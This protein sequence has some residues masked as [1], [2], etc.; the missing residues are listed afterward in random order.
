MNLD[1][2][3]SIDRLKSTDL[4]QAPQR[5]LGDARERAQAVRHDLHTRRESSRVALWTLSAEALEKA[6]DALEKAPAP[7]APVTGRLRKAVH[8][9]LN[10][11][12]KL[13]VEGYDDLNVKAVADLLPGLDRVNLERVA[14]YE[15]AHKDRVTVL[16]AVDKERERRLAAPQATA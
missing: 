4:R 7:L 3:A 6:E 15:A 8:E 10:Q 11:V 9:G 12:T 14:R 16:R 2:K 13:P 1:L 5:L